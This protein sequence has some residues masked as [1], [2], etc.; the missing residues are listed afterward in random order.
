MKFKSIRQ[1]AYNILRQSEKYTKTDMIYLTKGGFW[2][3]VKRIASIATGLG[4]SI[5][6]ANLLPQE[7]F[8][9]YKFIISLAAIIGAF[10]LTGMGVAVTQAV[11]NGYEGAIKKGLHE[12]LKWS[13]GMII[14]ALTGSVYYYFN[15]NTLLSYGLLIIAIT[16]PIINSFNLTPP[17]LKGK[18]E[19]KKETYYSF[20]K[21]F[22]PPLTLLTVIFI[23]NNPLILVAVYFGTQALI[24]MATYYY[25]LYTH[26]LNTRLNDKTLSFSKHLSLMGILEIIAGHIDKIL[27]FH[28]I[29]A[30][31]LAIYA[32]AIAPIRE[33]RTLKKFIIT[34]AFP[35]LSQR[36]ISEL[37]KTLPH[38]MIILF[39][40][41]TGI[42]TAYILAAP[43]IYKFIFPLY[44]ESV[45]FSQVFALTLLFMPIPILVETLT[46]HLKKRELYIIKTVTPLMR[47]ILLLI[48][49]PIYGLW[50]AVSAIL[51]TYVTNAIMVI[52]IFKRL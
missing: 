21:T 39:L 24:T 41:L 14:I 3:G 36:P 48:L 16:L 8:G 34:P 31:P 50:G 23:T 35:K 37:K 28:F 19:F 51:F 52:W 18:K 45:I 25:T 9:N 40:I 46:A 20:P 11:A 43:Y 49:L 4:L 6:F 7:V 15:N 47:I 13:W 29:G 5:A 22:I 10:S 38:R 44:L 42:V 26:T 17:F 27:L 33:I 30:A 2:V 12:N 32:F 1:T